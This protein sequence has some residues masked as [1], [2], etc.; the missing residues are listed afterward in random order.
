MPTQ[1]RVF[2]VAFIL[3]GLAVLGFVSTIL[4]RPQYRPLFSNIKESDGAAIIAKLKEAKVPYQIEGDGTTISVPADKV[5]ELTFQMAAA[6]LPEGGTTGFSIF[7]KT[8]FGMTEFS[9]K[10][11]YQRAMQGELERTLST[12]GEVAQARVH[13]ALPEERLYEKDRQDPTASIMLTLKPGGALDEERVAG[14]VHLV[15][16][17][18]EG[19]KPENITLMDNKGNLLNEL[20]SKDGTAGPKE[21][22]KQMQLALN[23]EERIKHDAQTMLDQALGPGKSVVRVKATL[24]FSQHELEKETYQPQPQGQGKGVLASQQETT[25]TYSGTGKPGAAPGVSANLMGSNPGGV[26]KADGYQRKETNSKWQV[27]K[28]IERLKDSPGKLTRLS[29]AVLLDGQYPAPRLQSMKQMVSAAV[30]ADATRG[31][32]VSVDAMPFDNS[33][34]VKQDTELKQTQKRD[35]IIYWVKAGLAIVLALV[36]LLFVKGLT[37]K[38]ATYEALAERALPADTT[39]PVL[40]A[41]DSAEPML[42]DAVIPFM[43]D[44]EQEILELAKENPAEAAQVMRTWLAERP[45]GS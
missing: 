43:E 24:D 3:S 23:Y 18:V 5:H 14:I 12:V 29:V 33:V 10:V 13:L 45:A 35:M 7:D 22:L 19:L 40:E 42:P 11:N 26:G 25:E 16:T 39:T 4:S 2:L 38:P 27:S 1:N 6:G 44:K 32:M 21:N 31:D 37:R 41:L 34:A 20:P 8:N 36:F 30:G 17:A 15:S 9:Q 28:Q